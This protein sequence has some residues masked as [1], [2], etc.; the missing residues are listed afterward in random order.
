M[1]P[2]A[3][4]VGRHAE[5]GGQPGGPSP[6]PLGGDCG[7]MGDGT[8]SGGGGIEIGIG[9]APHRS[10]EGRGRDALRGHG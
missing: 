2:M 9:T 10:G 8:P 3:Y 4:V 1:R 7:A 5:A 6:S